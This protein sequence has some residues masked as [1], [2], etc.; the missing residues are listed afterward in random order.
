MVQLLNLS[1]LDSDYKRLTCFSC[2]MK[3]LGALQ[4]YIYTVPV[5]YFNDTWEFWFEIIWITKT[6]STMFGRPI[7]HE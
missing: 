2:T 1:K 4:Q 3:F 7:V 6:D 5:A